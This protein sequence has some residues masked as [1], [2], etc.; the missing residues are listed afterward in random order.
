VNPGWHDYPTE[1]GL[2]VCFETTKVGGNTYTAVR[3]F[4]VIQVEGKMT[5][6]EHAGVARMFRTTD[7]SYATYRY[8]GPLPHDQQDQGET[9]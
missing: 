6:F 7:P 4:T 9:N 1:R 2:W 8:Y 3:Q 5:A